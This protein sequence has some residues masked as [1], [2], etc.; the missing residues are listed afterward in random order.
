MVWMQFLQN[1]PASFLQSFYQTC[2]WP[3][4]T[5]GQRETCETSRTFLSNMRKASSHVGAKRSIENMP[6]SL[7]QSFHQTCARPLPTL[8]QSETC[9]TCQHR[10][11]KVSI[12]DRAAKTSSLLIF[13]HHQKPNVPIQ[14]QAA[15]IFTKHA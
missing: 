3:L 8:G 9:E 12:Y 1:M 11:H 10:F 7:P 15:Q 5:L 4:S 6:A 13:A 14:F 2:T